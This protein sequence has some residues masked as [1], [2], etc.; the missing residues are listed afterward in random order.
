MI[1]AASALQWMREK[2][3][4]DDI[5]NIVQKFLPRDLGNFHTVQFPRPHT[6][7]A[8]GNEHFRIVRV[9]LITCD[10]FPNEF[11]VRL[12]IVK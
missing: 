12:V 3:L 6:Q 1:M 5:R 4:T 9:N 8:C 10:L 7:E 11:I 2:S